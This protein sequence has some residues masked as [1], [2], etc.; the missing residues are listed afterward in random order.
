MAVENAQRKLWEKIIAKAW[1][2]EDYKKRL[3]A[4]PA[5][6]LAAEGLI[7]PK[8]VNVNVVEA[9]KEQI[10]LVLPEQQ[11]EDAVEGEER[12]AAA[13]FW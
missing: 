4:D 6:V 7:L 5:G 8:G 13:N 12:L 9:T 3:L 2:D 11:A 1:A 10:W